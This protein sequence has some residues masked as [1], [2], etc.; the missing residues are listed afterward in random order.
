VIAVKSEEAWVTD[1]VKP[2]LKVGNSPSIIGPVYHISRASSAGN[3]AILDF[4]IQDAR[5][6]DGTAA[7][8][9]PLSDP[10]GLEYVRVVIFWSVYDVVLAAKEV[11]KYLTDPFG[12]VR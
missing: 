8:S 1:I 3:I 4:H 11:K 10:R 9:S 2:D 6:L 7:G 5:G 12:S